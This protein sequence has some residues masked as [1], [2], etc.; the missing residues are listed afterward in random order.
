MVLFTYEQQQQPEDSDEG[1]DLAGVNGPSGGDESEDE[2][3]LRMSGGFSSR[4]SDCVCIDGS[5]NDVK[6]GA[7]ASGVRVGRRAVVSGMRATSG[8]AAELALSRELLLG[9]AL[10]RAQ[11][12]APLVHA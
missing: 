9:V 5:V 2:S 12:V 11:N 4:S 6:L 3:M 8:G 1:E 10:G 7:M